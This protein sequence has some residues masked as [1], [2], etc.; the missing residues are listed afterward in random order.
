[1]QPKVMV[2]GWL[3]PEKPSSG[4]NTPATINMA[5]ISIDVVSIEK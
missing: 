1:M 5:I 4:L 3:N 2:A